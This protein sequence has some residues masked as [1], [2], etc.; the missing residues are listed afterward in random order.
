MQ[1]N[2]YKHPPIF[3]ET[4]TLYK[5]YYKAHHNLPKVFRFGVGEKILD[6]LSI[7]TKLIVLT[8]FNKIENN[9][10]KCVNYLQE[11][12]ARVEV[13]K[14]YFLLAW[15]MKFISN[16]F[17]TNLS[18]RIISISKQAARWQQFLQK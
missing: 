4:F 9:L 1:D 16:G 8:N 5:E 12:R 15:Q 17:Y 13:I 2:N 7:I 18:K 14:S 6:E 11:L 10:T 3:A